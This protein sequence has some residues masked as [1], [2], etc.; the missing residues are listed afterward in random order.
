MPPLTEEL[1]AKVELSQTLLE[2]A[3]Q[4]VI[5]GLSVTVTVVVHVSEQLA[6][7]A[8]KVMV[9]DPVV[10]GV[11]T[12]LAIVASSKLPLVAVQA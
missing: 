1:N 10:L 3:L 6:S 7:L 5:V 12:G 4:L 11:N 8:I 2:A 9:T